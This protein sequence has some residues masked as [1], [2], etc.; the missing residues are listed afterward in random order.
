M[1][2]F[3]NTQGIKFYLHP[4]FLNKALYCLDIF[5]H[6][7]NMEVN[8]AERLQLTCFASPDDKKE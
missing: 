6:F 5:Y 8:T 3:E 1:G 2:E 4:A 7:L